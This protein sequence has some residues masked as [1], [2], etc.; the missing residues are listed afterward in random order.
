ML[1]HIQ[2]V[3]RIH[4]ALVV[5]R[6][7]IHKPPANHPLSLSLLLRTEL[8]IWCYTKINRDLDITRTEE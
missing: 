1:R 4:A 6:H 2:A 3:Q 8:R 7:D 5:R